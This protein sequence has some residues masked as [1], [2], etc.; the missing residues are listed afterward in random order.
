MGE[1]ETYRLLYSYLAWCVVLGLGL[2]L[3]LPK[4][5]VTRRS[6]ALDVLPWVLLVPWWTTFLVLWLVWGVVQDYVV[7]AGL[8]L[9]GAGV[10]WLAS[11]S[12]GRRGMAV[13][14]AALHT[15]SAFLLGAALAVPLLGLTRWLGEVWRS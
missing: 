12:V 7:V 15:Q 6:H 3:A 10:L 8:V 2:T 4:G 5:W 9:L 14:A 1:A 13:L 11:R